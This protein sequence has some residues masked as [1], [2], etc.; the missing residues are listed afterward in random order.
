MSSSR[1]GQ[2]DVS[3]KLKAVGEYSTGGQQLFKRRGR[4]PAKLTTRAPRPRPL[5]APARG[6]KNLPRAEIIFAP[7]VFKT[8]QVRGTLMPYM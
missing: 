2:S 4:F 3:Q 8:L 1:T 5:L 6:L 7:S